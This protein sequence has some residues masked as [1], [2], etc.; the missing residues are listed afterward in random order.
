M[1]HTQ[2]LRS[3]GRLLLQPARDR[4]S[5]S[6]MRD[7][8]ASQLNQASYKSRNEISETKR[9]ETERNFIFLECSVCTT[10]SLTTSE[11]AGCLRRAIRGTLEVI[12]SR[13]CSGPAFWFVSRV[14]VEWCCF[15]TP[16][17]S[18]S[19]STLSV[20]RSLPVSTECDACTK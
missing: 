16:A 17:Q 6:S 12:D 5:T 2:H 9:N 19:A 14:C 11:G 18:T 7:S 13:N 3:R 10:G 20:S 1:C 4:S 8:N 15:G